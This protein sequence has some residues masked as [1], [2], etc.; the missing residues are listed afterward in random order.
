M[1]KLPPESTSSPEGRSSYVVLLFVAKVLQSKSSRV[2]ADICR[3]MGS[4][5]NL[6]ENESEDDIDKSSSGGVTS[7]ADVTM[8]SRKN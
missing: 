3:R 2:V 7:L 1:Q 6:E 5:C 4:R 8:L